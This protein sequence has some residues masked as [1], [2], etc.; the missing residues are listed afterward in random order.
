MQA[1]KSDSSGVPS[2]EPTRQPTTTTGV[3]LSLSSSEGEAEASASVTADVEQ[4]EAPAAPAPPSP[5]SQ[6]QNDAGSGEEG[7]FET[8]SV[9]AESIAAH[10]GSAEEL[11]EPSGPLSGPPRGF[12]QVDATLII[13]EQ[14]VVRQLS[15]SD[16]PTATRNEVQPPAHSSAEA[17]DDAI[18]QDIDQS[19]PKRSHRRCPG[20]HAATSGR[21]RVN[22][23]KRPSFRSFRKL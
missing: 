7:S 11:V 23:T 5:S 4:P 12:P 21:S 19:S 22:P 13:S 1:K 17:Q 16:I 18:V 20:R 6:P 8:A 10:E 9:A 14:N 2:Q 3:D 15:T